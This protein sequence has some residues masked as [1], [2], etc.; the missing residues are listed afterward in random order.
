MKNMN[1]L[2]EMNN[3][4]IERLSPKPKVRTFDADEERE[5]RTSLVEKEQVVRSN[6]DS[7]LV[8]SENK[9][10]LFGP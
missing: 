2:H 8:L 10:D 3:R 9:P 4:V 7:C 5:I 1:A 6:C